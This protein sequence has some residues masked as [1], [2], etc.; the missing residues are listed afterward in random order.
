MLLKD[1]MCRHGARLFRGRSYLPLLLVPIIVAAIL[2]PAP[3]DHWF[4]RRAE[5]F[6]ELGSLVVAFTGLMVRVLTTGFV[7]AGTSGR[8]TSRQIADSLNTTGFY[9]VTRNPLYLG[10]FLVALGIVLAIKVWWLVLIAIIA[11]ALYYERIIFAEEAFL[12]AKFGADYRKWTDRTP[13]FF[14][15]FRLWQAP[16]QTFSVRTVLRREFHGLYLIVVVFTLV[17]LSHDMAEGAS[18]AAWIAKD[19][20]WPAFF[21]AGTLLYLF[22]MF[23]KKR[24]KLLQMDGR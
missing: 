5:L 10:N 23:L 20:A 18:L 7:P 22:L 16:Q 19:F 14:P 4:S 11:F 24:T 9:S 12:E 1:L 2:Q 15:N 8:N 6:W 21:W 3:F 17:D 13:A